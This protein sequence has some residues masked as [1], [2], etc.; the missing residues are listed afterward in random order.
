MDVAQNMCGAAKGSG[1]KGELGVE[2][3]VEL[4]AE[5]GMELGMEL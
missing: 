3:Q 1:L 5:L 4:W 2:W